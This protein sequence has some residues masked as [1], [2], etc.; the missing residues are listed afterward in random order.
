MLDHNRLLDTISVM[1][2]DQR[3]TLDEWNNASTQQRAIWLRDHVLIRSEDLEALRL[4]AYPPRTQPE[5]E[6]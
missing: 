3:I 6:Q 5:D 2:N 4:L 1:S